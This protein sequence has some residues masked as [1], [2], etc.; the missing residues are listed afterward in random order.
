MTPRIRYATFVAAAFL[1]GIVG[2]VFSGLFFSSHTA[3][4]A[5]DFTLPTKPISSVSVPA[6]GFRFLLPNGKVIARMIY[7]PR[8]GTRFE[9]LGGQQTRTVVSAGSNKAAVSLSSGNTR[10]ALLQGKSY[11]GH[12]KT[13]ALYL[14]DGF[15]SVAG[16]TTA[17]TNYQYYFPRRSEIAKL[18]QPSMKN[19]PRGLKRQP[20]RTSVYTRPKVKAKLP[21]SHW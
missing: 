21:S 16:Q 3:L 18:D 15:V 5:R 10:M 12:R 8:K 4:A 6:E 1:G 13:G 9:V 17:G 14:K 19:P 20:A 11:A 2:G 7:D